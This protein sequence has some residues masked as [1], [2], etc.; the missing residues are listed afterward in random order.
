MGNENIIVEQFE[1]VGAS[2]VIENL[3]NFGI[4]RDLQLLVFVLYSWEMPKL[5]ASADFNFCVLTF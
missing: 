4:A 5:Q 2:H 1:M 3:I